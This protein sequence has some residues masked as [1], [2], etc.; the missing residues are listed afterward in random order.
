[1]KGFQTAVYLSRI[2]TLTV[3]TW[4]VWEIIQLGLRPCQLAMVFSE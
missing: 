3:I 1:M 4:A 2:C